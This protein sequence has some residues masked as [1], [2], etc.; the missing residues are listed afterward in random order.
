MVIPPPQ[1]M[2]SESD[3]GMVQGSAVHRLTVADFLSNFPTVNL[4]TVNRELFPILYRFSGFVQQIK[5]TILKSS[6]Y[7]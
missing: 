2:Q 4:L 7:D 1:K 6:E 3:T 5:V